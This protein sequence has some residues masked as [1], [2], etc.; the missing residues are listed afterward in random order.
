MKKTRK[1]LKYIFILII[2]ILFIR[3]LSLI[4][5]ISIDKEYVC[6]EIKL[7]DPSYEV[8]RT[9]KIKGKYYLNLHDDR[10]KGHISI[11]G[12][13]IDNKLMDEIIFSHNDERKLG[14]MSY[15]TESE[16]K[17]LFKRQYY[18]LGLIDQRTILKKPYM[19]ILK[20]DGSWAPNDGIC[21]IPPY[22]DKEKAMEILNENLRSKWYFIDVKPD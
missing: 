5:P 20:Q 15:F 1:I 10:F 12:Y 4:I 8:E 22:D 17:D 11:S 19:L 3:F 18:S 16:D 14:H 6:K 21:I 9:I 7:D 13:N 2:S